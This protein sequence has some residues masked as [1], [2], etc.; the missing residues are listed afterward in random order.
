MTS[1]GVTP[2]SHLA[3]FDLATWTFETVIGSMAPAN[4]LQAARVK[5]C[6][7]QKP[8]RPSDERL[9]GILAELKVGDDRAG[10]AGTADDDR[11]FT[12]LSLPESS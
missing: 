5:C 7:H 1:F 4:Q 10:V 3:F 9:D 6:D 12:D 8:E 11:G 2:G